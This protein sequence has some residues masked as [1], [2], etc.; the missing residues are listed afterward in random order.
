MDNISLFDQ[1]SFI[2]SLLFVEIQKIHTIRCC[3][4][5]Q[6]RICCCNGWSRQSHHKYSTRH[7]T[8][9]IQGNLRIEVIGLAEF[10][11]AYT[12]CFGVEI[13]Q[14]ADR[15]EEDI[16]DHEYPGKSHHILLRL[17][18]G[19]HAQVLLHQILIQSCHG[20]GHEHTSYNMLQHMSGIAQEVFP[21][22]NLGI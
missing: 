1:F 16:D 13:Q 5:C 11:Y 14:R 12:I 9:I 21:H 4:C 22:E 6:C 2:W 3:Q 8:Q 17:S 18:N 10:G 15:K 7:H 19:S 20:Y